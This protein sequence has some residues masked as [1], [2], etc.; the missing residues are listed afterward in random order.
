MHDPVDKSLPEFKGQMLEVQQDKNQK[1]PLLKKPSRPITVKDVLSHASG[2]PFMSRVERK[3]DTY[4]LREAVLSYASTPLKSEPGTKFSYSNAGINT[5][6][7]I[8]EVLGGVPFEEFLDKRLFQPLGMKDTTFWPS[9]EQVRRLAKS[10]RPNAAKNDLE[11]T[12]IGQLTYPLTDRRRGPCPAGGLF[13]TAADVAIFCRMILGGGMY[14]GRRYVSEAS[15]R[16]MTSPQMGGYGLGWSTSLRPG[17]KDKPATVRECGHGGAYSTNMSID[18]EHQLITVYMVQ[19]A[20]YPG[21]DGGRVR[22][23]F[24]KAAQEAFVK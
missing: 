16:Q 2:L 13:S 11:E 15:V 7:R 9:E 18:H 17:A 3:I 22:A 6:G 10:Y 24:V 14:E 8:V 23:T 5:A 20:G 4:P 19:H 21:K 1:Q 12:E